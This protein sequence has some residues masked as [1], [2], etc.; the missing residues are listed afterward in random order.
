MKNKFMAEI[1]DYSYAED[2]LGMIE[3]L[4]LNFSDL[5]DVESDYAFKALRPQF[6]E[7]MDYD[8]LLMGLCSMYARPFGNALLKYMMAKHKEGTDLKCSLRLD[9]TLDEYKIKIKTDVRRIAYACRKGQDRLSFTGSLYYNS[10]AK[11]PKDTE[12]VSVHGI[13]D[14]NY[15]NRLVKELEAYGIIL[16]EE[17]TKVREDR[18]TMSRQP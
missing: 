11:D 6:P 9:R 15:L 1:R 16:P 14:R 13:L 8:N 18:H 7:K 12:W 10:M 5:D 2:Y 3:Y 4:M 17:Y